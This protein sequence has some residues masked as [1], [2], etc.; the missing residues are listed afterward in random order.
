MHPTS[1]FM[2]PSCQQLLA[3]GDKSLG[4]CLRTALDTD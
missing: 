4:T 1:D 3:Q 2:T